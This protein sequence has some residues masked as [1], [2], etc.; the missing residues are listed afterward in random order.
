MA[1]EY[2]FCL[3]EQRRFA[4][5]VLL[6]G[7]HEQRVRSQYRREAGRAQPLAVAHGAGAREYPPHAVG[8]RRLVLAVGLAE[9]LARVAAEPQRAIAGLAPVAVGVG[10]DQPVDQ[11]V[12]L[13]ALAGRAL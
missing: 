2:A 9:L 11:V 8:Q 4:L 12:R 3:A 6:E 5:R 10:V 1:A 7:L 13:P